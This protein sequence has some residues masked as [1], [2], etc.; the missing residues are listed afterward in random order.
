MVWRPTGSRA[1]RV[2]RRPRDTAPSVIA[3]AG[4]VVLSPTNRATLRL[5]GDG[6][7]A[8]GRSVLLVDRSR[9]PDIV[10]C[11]K[12][13][14]QAHCNDV[15]DAS[16][17]TVRS[18]TVVDVDGRDIRR[19]RRGA[20][21]GRVDGQTERVRWRHERRQSCDRDVAVYA[22]LGR[23][24]VRRAG[25]SRCRG[26]T[27]CAAP[28]DGRRAA[29]VTQPGMPVSIAASIPHVVLEIGHGEQHKSLATI[30]ELCSGFA[31][32]GLT[33]NDVVIA[34]GGGMVTDVAGFAA[35]YVPPWRAGGPRG[36]HAAGDGRCRDRWQDRRQPARGQEPGRRVLA[37]TRRRVRPR[38]ARDAARRASCAAATA[39]WPSTTS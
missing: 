18:P 33:R 3:A 34:V 25:R 38:R 31:E 15:R 12:T 4:G 32:M 26:P 22:S 10:L 37:A 17:C 8:A 1:A 23:A 6:R 2:V 35:A 16:T 13:I 14:R 7:V 5:R 39:R 27:R 24:L 36:D 30:A 29:V 28:A 9:A 20:R 11:S 21:G 19:R